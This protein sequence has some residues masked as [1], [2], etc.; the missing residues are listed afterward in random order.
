MPNSRR[1]ILFGIAG[2]PVLSGA[3][4]FSGDQHANHQH[5][6]AEPAPTGADYKPQVFS[7]AELRTIGALAETILPRTKTPGALDAKVHE[8]I[9]ESLVNR[10]AAQAAWRKGLAEVSRL[11]KKLHK[12]EYADLDSGAQAAV[13]TELAASSKFF[14]TLKDSTIDAYYS[15]K[16]G[17][18]T[19]LGWNAALPMPKFDGCTHKEHQS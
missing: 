13:M 11:S 2:A 5:S 8:I 3:G 16:E 15:T 18:Q 7:A 10:K 9:D 19:E 4:A 14:P 17:L 12:R 1:Q 6:F